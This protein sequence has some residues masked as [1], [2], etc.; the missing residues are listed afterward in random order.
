MNFRLPFKFPF[1]VC[2]CFVSL[3]IDCVW[4]FIN[5]SSVA[6]I[7]HVLFCNKYIAHRQIEYSAYWFHTIVFFFIAQIITLLFYIVL[8][9][10]LKL[11]RYYFCVC[12]FCTIRF[13]CDFFIFVV[14]GIWFTFQF[15]LQFQWQLFKSSHQRYACIYKYPEK[16]FTIW[17]EWLVR[18]LNTWLAVCCTSHCIC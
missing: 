16:N 3:F 17:R 14:A 2:K 10:L 5:F 4:P 18:D 1:F 9:L 7:L 15:L 8:H 6:R 12:A 13:V 11:F